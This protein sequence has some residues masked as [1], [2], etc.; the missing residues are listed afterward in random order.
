M[1]TIH[2]F[3]FNKAIELL[4]NNFY[5]TSDEEGVNIYF[6]VNT[7]NNDKEFQQISKNTFIEIEK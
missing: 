3:Y 1:M 4:W 6:Y 2:E 7:S 5:K